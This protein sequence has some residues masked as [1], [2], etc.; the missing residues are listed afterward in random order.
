[1]LRGF[2]VLGDALAE[3]VPLVRVRPVLLVEGRAALRRRAALRFALLGSG[4]RRVVLIFGL[5]LVVV[6]ISLALVLD[7]GLRG[8]AFPERV[9][10]VRVRSVLLVEGRAALRRRAALG[11]ARL[12]R[13]GLVRRDDDLRLSLA[14][15]VSRAL[16]F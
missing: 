3:R 13:I 11:L 10:L 4:S 2:C 5:G 9:S 1:M 8:N 6:L 7:L 12:R 14:M 16:T 15:A